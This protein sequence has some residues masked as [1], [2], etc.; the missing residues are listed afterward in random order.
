M[1]ISFRPVEER[2]NPHTSSCF[3][4][5]EGVAKVLATL[6][7]QEGLAWQQHGMHDT[8]LEIWIDDGVKF[9]AKLATLKPTPGA[10]V[11]LAK[12]ASIDLA[13]VKQLTSLVHNLS[14]LAGQWNSSIDSLD[15]SLT[16]YIDVY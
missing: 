1:S 10:M 4:S 9:L 16:F 14:N 6:A 12:Q 5:P 15:G 7:E 11:E 2:F 8:H 3:L 13:D